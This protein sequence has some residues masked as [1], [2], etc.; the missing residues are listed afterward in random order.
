MNCIIYIDTNK[1][2]SGFQETLSLYFGNTNTTAAIFNSTSLS[3]SP[4]QTLYFYGN[5]NQTVNFLF[6]KESPHKLR[7]FIEGVVLRENLDQLTSGVKGILSQT[8]TFAKKNNVNLSN[9][10]AT[11]WAE[12]EE[13]MKGEVPRYWVHFRSIFPDLPTSIYL[14]ILIV[15]YSFIKPQAGSGTKDSFINLGIIILAILIW[16]FIK[17]GYKKRELTFKIK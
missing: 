3:G 5:T 8:L 9:I 11:I 12:G 6:S 14:S 10:S 13:M 15:L 1:E 7:I 4:F 16:Q 2:I 17:T